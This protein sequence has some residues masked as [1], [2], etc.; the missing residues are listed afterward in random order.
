[1]KSN[2]RKRLKLLE[3]KIAILMRH[4]GLR[5]SSNGTTFFRGSGNFF[6]LRLLVVNCWWW[7]ETALL[8]WPNPSQ[9][10]DFPFELWL[11]LRMREKGREET[12]K[13]S[14]TISDGLEYFGGEA[15]R[16][17]ILELRFQV[18]I[19]Q[20]IQFNSKK[21]SSQC[22]RSFPQLEV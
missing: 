8:E 5:L 9:F 11:K 2:I 13:G 15:R 17:R 7:R 3:H 22:L 4:H 21:P 16:I 14:Y 19:F 6:L 12:L 1:M 10:I 20:E 18:W